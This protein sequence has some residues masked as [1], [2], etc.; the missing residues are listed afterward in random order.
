MA[1]LEARCP[2]AY[3]GL[4]ATVCRHVCAYGLTV[5]STETEMSLLRA[6][7]PG[8]MWKAER[9]RVHSIVV[10]GTHPYRDCV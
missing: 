3:G 4:G 6:L 2:A 9:A 5:A 7:M 10:R 1:A 8:A